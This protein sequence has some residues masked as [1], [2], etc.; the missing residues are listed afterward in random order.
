MPPFTR[1]G[2]VI[3]AVLMFLTLLYY[4]LPNTNL[5]LGRS[6]LVLA[7]A[8]YF[9]FFFNLTLTLQ[10]LVMGQLFLL[11]NTTFYAAMACML[12][13]PVLLLLPGRANELHGYG[14]VYFSILGVLLFTSLQILL[15]I[16]LTE[17][18]LILKLSSAPPLVIPWTS[19]SDIDITD[20][21]ITIR[22]G[23]TLELS[24]EA[25]SPRQWQRLKAALR[26]F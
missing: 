16:R 12:F 20:D 14:L 17:D 15:R 19:I 11:R 1:V 9:F 7:A 10:Q 13:L 22:A 4:I 25:F 5:L 2:Q 8:V 26:R 18:A 21:L 6:V 23:D 3:A 24:R